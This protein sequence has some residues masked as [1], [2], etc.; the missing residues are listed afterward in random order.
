MNDTHSDD[1]QNSANSSA[2]S[3]TCGTVPLDRFVTDTDS[4]HSLEYQPVDCADGR[5]WPWVD[6]WT[7]KKGSECETVLPTAAK[8][9]KNEDASVLAEEFLTEEEKR[10]ILQSAFIRAA[11]HGDV[12]RIES[13]LHGKAREYIDLDGRD[14]SGGTAIIFAACYGHQSV[15]EAL[16]EAGADIHVQDKGSSELACRVY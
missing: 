11:S 14:E 7:G 12:E 2:H 4:I 16:L 5:E 3:S 9:T 10:G 1:V 15:V 13:M 6:P 8:S